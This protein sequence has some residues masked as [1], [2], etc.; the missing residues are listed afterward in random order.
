MSVKFLHNKVLSTVFIEDSGTENVIESLCINLEQRD[1][2]EAVNENENMQ[3]CGVLV[4]V[5]IVGKAS[6]LR[7]TFN[8]AMSFYLKQ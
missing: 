6:R 8:H 4:L 5:I 7:R 3:I 2:D 1:N